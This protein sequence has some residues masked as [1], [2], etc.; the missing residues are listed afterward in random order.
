MSKIR[1][2]FLCKYYPPEPGGIE[3][4]S[5][6]LVQFS[7]NIFETKILSFK[8]K[9]A[10][11]SITNNTHNDNIK[12]FNS[13]EF[14]RQPISLRYFLASISEGIKIKIIYIHYPNILSAISVII[15]KF[16]RPK[17]KIIVHYHADLI[18][19]FLFFNLIYYL[20]TKILLRLSN[21]IIVT[22]LNYKKNS[23]YLKKFYN[24]I[25]II[26]LS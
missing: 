25:E 14:F 13:I 10:D 9:C 15:A 7:N 1:I 22:S 18:L 4:V 19:N 12:S 5:K 23:K 11:F 17:V 8:K 26:P 20:I 24:K 16:L 21:G 6:K 3:N 2:L